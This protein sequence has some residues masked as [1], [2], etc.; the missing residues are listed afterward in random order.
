MT[1]QKRRNK[2]DPQTKPKTSSQ[3]IDVSTD[4][5]FGPLTLQSD[6]VILDLKPKEASPWNGQQKITEKA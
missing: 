1:S 5:I 2:Y 4:V 6:F 3:K